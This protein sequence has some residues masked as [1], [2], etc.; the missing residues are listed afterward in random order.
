VTVVAVRGATCE[1]AN[2]WRS[3]EPHRLG[4]LFTCDDGLAR[5]AVFWFPAWVPSALS[6]AEASNAALR[7][8]LV[9][10][11]VGGAPTTTAYLFALAGA[12]P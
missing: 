5:E 6:K 3:V 2:R 9:L 8:D 10:E 7:F 4:I 11:T 12:M 1:I